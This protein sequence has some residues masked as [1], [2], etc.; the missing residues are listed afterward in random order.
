MRDV[1]I[2]EPIAHI[3]A[4]VSDAPLLH[5][6]GGRPHQGSHAGHRHDGQPVGIAVRRGPG[7][8]CRPVLGQ[9][10]PSTS[11]ESETGTVN[12]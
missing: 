4:G 10:L 11:P 1:G 6:E 3:F 7:G 9:D 8:R 12:G 2:P 5:R